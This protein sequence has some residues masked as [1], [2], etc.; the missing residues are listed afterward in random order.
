[1]PTVLQRLWASFTQ[2][3]L[4]LQ[5]RIV[6]SMRDLPHAIGRRLY[7]VGETERYKWAILSCPC[8]CGKRI[9]ICLMPSAIPRWHLVLR[10]GDATLSPSIWVPRERC[11]SHFWIRNS[12]IIW[13]ER[14][15]FD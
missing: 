3:P 9:D 7:I 2:R 4:T 6:R 1:M 14:Q 11:G 10:G 15:Q 12:Q 13:C 8:G 5:V